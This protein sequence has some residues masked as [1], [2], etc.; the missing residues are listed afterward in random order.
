M[1]KNC[2]LDVTDLRQKWDN[3]MQISVLALLLFRESTQQWCNIIS[4]HCKLSLVR[5]RTTADD[6]T[7]I[8][9]IFN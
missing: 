3:K 5:K 9:R 6:K 8:E 2:Q 1:E 4:V 7:I